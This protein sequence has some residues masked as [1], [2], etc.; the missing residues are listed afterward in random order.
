MTKE[1]LKTEQA[2]RNLKKPHVISCF[3]KRTFIEVFCKKCGVRYSDDGE[4]EKV[5]TDKAD[6]IETITMDDNWLVKGAN[7][8]C[9]N[10][11]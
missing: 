10:C 6:A 5:F 11:R 1:K 4:Y 9:E 3:R 7:A 8:F 2:N